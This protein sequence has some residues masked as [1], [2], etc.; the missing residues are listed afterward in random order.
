LHDATFTVLLIYVD[1][2]IIAEND[3]VEK[4][5]LKEE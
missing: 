5:M 1:D 2:M 4:Q 3:E